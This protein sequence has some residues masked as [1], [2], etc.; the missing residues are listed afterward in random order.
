[1]KI[2][3]QSAEIIYPSN[4]DAAIEGM[5]QC[6]YA[7]RNCYR[8]HDKITDDSYGRF[9]HSLISRGHMSPLEFGDVVVELVTSRDVMAEQTRH[10]LCSFAIQS[11][12][13]VLDDRSG[14]ISFIRPD[15][16]INSNDDASSRWVQSMKNAEEDYKYMIRCGMKPQ[17]AR[18]V[19]PN[20]TATV[21]IM[22]TNHREWRQIFS[23]RWSDAAYPEMRTLM[24]LLVPQFR[25]LFD[26]I[27]DDLEAPHA[28]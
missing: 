9:I 26:G 8:S 2:I 7:G 1:M 21:I 17:D 6:E 14:E 19:L 23:L 3:Q 22:K 24:S 4:I 15:F 12:R 13:Y 11:Q 5:K 27:Y 28:E 16:F 10:R 20:S 25:H 18:K